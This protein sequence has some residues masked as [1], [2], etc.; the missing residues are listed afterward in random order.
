MLATGRPSRRRCA[1]DVGE[2]TLQPP[3]PTR[4]QIFDLATRQR[5]APVLLDGR[6]EHAEAAEAILRIVVEVAGPVGELGPG[7][8]QGGLHGIELLTVRPVMDHREGL[9]E[10][11]ELDARQL[12][13]AAID[14]RVLCRL[15]GDVVPDAQVD[16]SPDEHEGI[17]LII[18]E[19]NR[20]DAF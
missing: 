3:F 14:D 11:R 1:R 10:R 17:A 16:G 9:V 12:L 15:V 4:P 2:E 7:F 20:G 13:E 19:G 8:A 18:A 5:C 6:K